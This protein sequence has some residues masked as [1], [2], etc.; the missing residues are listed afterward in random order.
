[1]I[2]LDD[3][4]QATKYGFLLEDESKKTNLRLAADEAV[5]P[6]QAMA[7]GD[8]YRSLALGVTDKRV[9]AAMLGRARG[10]YEQYLGSDPQ[11]LKRAKA[12]LTLKQIETQIAALGP[13]AVPAR[14]KVGRWIDLL[15]KID[16]SGAGTGNMTVN[17]GVLSGG[18]RGR[19]SVS[20][21]AYPEG[22]YELKF[23]MAVTRS[24]GGQ[25]GVAFHLPVGRSST[26]FYVFAQARTF[27]DKKPRLAAFSY[28]EDKKALDDANP[29]GV[30]GAVKLD[31]S[32]PFT[33]RVKTKGEKASLE[34]IVS[35]RTISKWSGPVD[36][37][38][39]RVGAVTAN[40]V[41]D[42]FGVQASFKDVKIR[43]LSGK[44]GAGD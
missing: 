15:A 10:Y 12:D 26:H 23:S 34:V 18:N 42:I 3:P 29:T 41:L 37:V 36:Q 38:R 35:G 27:G 13:V 24:A 14:Q 40:P 32:Y 39:P 22:D 20:F 5:E 25:A 1:L 8:W 43:M 9:K 11:G 28:V 7:L 33:V 31:R 16:L 44:L 6:D 21:V 2:E 17:G 4:A 19:N 30:P